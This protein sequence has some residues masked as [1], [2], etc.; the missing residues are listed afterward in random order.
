[1][2]ADRKHGAGEQPAAR[3]AQVPG[4]AESPPKGKESPAAKQAPNRVDPTEPTQAGR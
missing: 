2:E 3:P 4:D 1:M